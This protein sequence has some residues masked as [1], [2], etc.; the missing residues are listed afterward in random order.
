MKNSYFFRKKVSRFG[1]R[2]FHCMCKWSRDKADTP[3]PLWNFYYWPF[4]MCGFNFLCRR[5]QI[6]QILVWSA[7]NNTTSD[8]LFCARQLYCWHF[9]Q[10][11]QLLIKIPENKDCLLFNCFTSSH[12]RRVWQNFFWQGFAGRRTCAAALG[13]VSRRIRSEITIRYIFVNA[14]VI[15][16]AVSIKICHF[17]PCSR[18]YLNFLTQIFHLLSSCPSIL[19]TSG[20]LPAW[21]V[22]WLQYGEWAASDNSGLTRSDF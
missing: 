7:W 21:E 5:R 18:D 15:K 2:P 6:S 12:L 8:K 9:S 4:Y 22:T 13:V 1:V 14:W 16:G 10:N 19:F 3:F 17:H 11:L 20:D